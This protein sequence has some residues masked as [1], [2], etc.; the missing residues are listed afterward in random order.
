MEEASHLSKPIAQ[1]ANLCHHF[2][3]YCACLKVLLCHL[4]S[5]AHELT[6]P[7][8]I[9]VSTVQRNS[10]SSSP[11]SPSIRHVVS[12]EDSSSLLRD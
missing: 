1:F 7:F 6:S 8:A 5:I 3:S 4:V 10:L 2:D 12:L 11:D 9:F